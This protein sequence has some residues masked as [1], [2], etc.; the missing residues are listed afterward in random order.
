MT[1]EEICA[2]AANAGMVAAQNNKVEH[3]RQLY[4]H[5][6]ANDFP[7]PAELAEK[8]AVIRDKPMPWPYDQAPERVRAFY[9]VFRAVA[10]A[11]EPFAAPDVVVQE[12]GSQLW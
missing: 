11:L 7:S 6:V 12:E 9:E 2:Y 10:V 5:A 1:R 4:D 8:H 3:F